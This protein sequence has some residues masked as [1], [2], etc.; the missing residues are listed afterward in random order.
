MPPAQ[1][2]CAS[3]N[4]HRPT[5]MLHNLMD[6]LKSN[7]F[8]I[9]NPTPWHVIQVELIYLC[10]VAKNHTFLIINGPILIPLSKPQACE[11]MFTTHKWF[12]LLHCAPNPTSLKA[13]LTMMSDNNLP[14]SYWSCFVV[15]YAIPS[16]SSVTRV[17]QRLFYRLQEALDALLFASRSCPLYPSSNALHKIGFCPLI[18]QLCE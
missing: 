10:Q 16:Q 4:H 9:S 12:L 3:P 8:S 17:T 5:T 18:W 1:K 14:I 6:M 13:R 7:A 2:P 15:A 11:S